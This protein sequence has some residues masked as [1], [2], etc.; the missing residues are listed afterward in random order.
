MIKEY[1]EIGQIVST[2]G[3]RGEVRLNPW[4]DSPE[5]AN[6]FKTFYFD[7]KGTQP[8]KAVSCRPHG[9]IAI[10]KLEGVDTVEQANALRNRMLW[11]KRSDAHL[12]EGQWFINE[13]IGC[14]VLDADDETLCYG[15]LTDVAPTGANDVWY[16]NTPDGREVLIPAIKDVVKKCDVAENRVYIKPLGG[17][18]DCED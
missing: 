12:P 7:E 17:L 13:L 14:E 18:F 8:V 6:K 4:C 3:I 10:L 1:L 15:T 9:N 5:F 16:I 11:F 2:H